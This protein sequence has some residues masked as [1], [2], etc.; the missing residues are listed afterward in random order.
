[1]FPEKTLSKEGFEV[2]KGLLT[3]IP[4]KRLDAAAALHLPW[5]ANAD[6]HAPVPALAPS[7]APVVA[8]VS[9]SG[10]AAMSIWTMASYSWQV[11]LSCFDRSGSR[12]RK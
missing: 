1:M 12:P 11:A 7:P 2:L 4:S 5:F 8:A 9:K 3:C 10:G 6:H